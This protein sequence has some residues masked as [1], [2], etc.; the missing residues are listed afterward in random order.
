M[1]DIGRCR[2]VDILREIGWSQQ[3]LANHS[4]LDKRTV[5]FY[6][7]NRRK[8]M[9]LQIAVIISDTINNKTDVE[10]SPRDLYEWIPRPRKN[11]RR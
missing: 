10:V 6:A 9:P 1:Y 8:K 3:D 4:G 2:V 5:S 7:T 11:P